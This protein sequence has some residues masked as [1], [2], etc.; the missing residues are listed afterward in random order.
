MCCSEVLRKLYFTLTLHLFCKTSGRKERFPQLE[1][2]HTLPKFGVAMRLPAVYS[3][4]IS[5]T[6]TSKPREEEEEAA[7][8]LEGTRREVSARLQEC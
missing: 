1:D 2:S 3:A 8:Q 5:L 4:C 7:K 6:V